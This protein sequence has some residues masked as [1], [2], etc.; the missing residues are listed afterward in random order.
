MAALAQDGLARDHNQPCRL[1]PSA[2]SIT[3][4]APNTPAAAAAAAAAVDSAAPITLLTA[5]ETCEARKAWLL[6]LRE[7]L[8]H[9][10]LKPGP[11][12][13][14]LSVFVT[15]LDSV[16]A[17]KEV[18]ALPSARARE[19]SFARMHT[20]VHT[21]TRASRVT[22]IYQHQYSAGFEHV[23][24]AEE[25]AGVGGGEREVGWR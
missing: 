9:H 19:R 21:S 16:G 23:P 4:P 5:E 1:S 12:P 11:L 22:Q 25:E 20:R 24:P 10:C 7:S 3:T 14:T 8:N 13:S 6:R 18:C 17:R 2:H 15:C